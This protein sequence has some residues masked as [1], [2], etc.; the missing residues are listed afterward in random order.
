MAQ[1]PVADDRRPHQ[2]TIGHA[3][4]APAPG[5]AA[6]PPFVAVQNGWLRRRR[7]C[8][9]RVR[10]SS[11]EVIGGVLV[12]DDSYTLELRIPGHD[13]TALVFKHSVEYLVPAGAG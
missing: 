12:G 2:G 4:A 1:A 5:G 10:L 3:P 13:E 11:G 8:G 7:G 6:K 9:V